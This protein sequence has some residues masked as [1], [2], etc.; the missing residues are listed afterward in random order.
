MAQIPMQTRTRIF[1]VCFVLI[2]SLQ[3]FT[4]NSRA[5]D[6][7][8]ATWKQ[9]LAVLE[10]LTP[11]EVAACQAVLVQIRAEVVAWIAAHPESGA[12]LN[13]LQSLPLTDEQAAALVRELRE[14]VSNI[15]AADPSHPF[16]LGQT[17]VEV[18]ASLGALAPSSES[19][20]RTEI[21]QSDAVNVTRAIDQL[22]GVEIQAPERSSKS[23][24][25]KPSVRPWAG[26]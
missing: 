20:S 15:V 14:A 9:D 3:S 18:R 24:R 2:L 21:E 13:Q 16:H 10:K 11:G 4:A 8:P 26:P 6:G 22:P 17:D 19:I 23:A 1:L 25:T 7:R 5:E 12:K